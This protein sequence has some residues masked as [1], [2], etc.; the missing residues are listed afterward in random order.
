MLT[1]IVNVWM[2]WREETSI[3]GLGVETIAAFRRDH[4]VRPS[5]RPRAAR[6]NGRRRAPRAG[7]GIRRPAHPS[8]T[9]R[10]ARAV[11]SAA[12]RLGRRHVNGADSVACEASAEGPR[13]RGAR[14]RGRDVGNPAPPFGHASNVYI[15]KTIAPSA[16]R[17]AG[18][19]RLR[20]SAPRVM[21]CGPTSA[22][23]PRRSPNHGIDRP[24]SGW[25][26]SSRRRFRFEFRA[27]RRAD[28]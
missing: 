20:T 5:L 12:E 19:D 6:G 2:R 1:N 22:P 8:D 21:T 18:A 25:S 11:T 15:G 10:R 26:P 7:P 3:S 13:M 4:P 24:G 28:R 9:V 17:M 14:M 23:P 16:R 27:N